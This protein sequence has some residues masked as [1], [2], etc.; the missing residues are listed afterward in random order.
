M[1]LIVLLRLYLDF[2]S[3]CFALFTFGGQSI[4]RFVDP[5]CPLMVREGKA[6]IFKHGMNPFN[7]YPLAFS[8]V[9][10]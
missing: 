6:D 1:Y 3:L 5:S 2:F 7:C 9:M 10:R 4:K 8:E